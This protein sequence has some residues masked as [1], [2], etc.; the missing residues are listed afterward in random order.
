MSITETAAVVTAAGTVLGGGG[1]FVAR[2]TIR[3]ARVTSAAQE[4]IARIQT[5]PQADAHRFTVLQA[6]VNRV[7]EENGQLRGRVS[8]VE[9]V[10]RAFAWTT[11]RWA[12]Q[13]HR[14]GIEPEPVHPLVDEYNRTGV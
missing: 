9:S 10:L 11:D 3:A 5:E 13:M 1:F 14:A 12:G 4:A 7:D 8:R 6:T 2:A